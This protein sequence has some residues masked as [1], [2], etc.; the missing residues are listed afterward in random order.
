[1][2]SCKILQNGRKQTMAR[3]FELLKSKQTNKQTK[4]QKQNTTWIQH[5]SLKKANTWW[6]LLNKTK[7]FFI[8]FALQ[9]L[10]LLYLLDCAPYFKAIFLFFFLHK[11][12]SLI[13]QSSDPFAWDYVKFS[14]EW[15]DLVYFLHNKYG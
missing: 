5:F 10:H 9:I 1:M 14:R 13:N 15:T 7:H 3:K 12:F 2:I 11:S 8:V 4:T 6:H